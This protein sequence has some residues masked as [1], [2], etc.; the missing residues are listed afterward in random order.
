MAATHKPHGLKENLFVALLLGSLS[1]PALSQVVTDGSVGPAMALTGPDFQIGENLGTR[2]GGN[3]FHS[4]GQFSLSQEQSAT[5]TGSGDIDHVISRVTGGQASSIDGLLKSEV[6]NADFWFINPAGVVFGPNARLEVPAAFHL[7]SADQ[8]QFADGAVFSAVDANGS[9][10]TTAAPEAFGFLAP[11]PE[12]VR[13]EASQLELADGQRMTLSGGSL[14]VENAALSA[15]DGELHLVAVGGAAGGAAEVAIMADGDPSLAGGMASGDLVVENSILSVEGLSGGR[16]SLQGG[17]TRLSMSE[18]AART[19]WLGDGQGLSISANGLLDVEYSRISTSTYDAGKAGNVTIHA[20]S[21]VIDGFGDPEG[22]IGIFSSTPYGSGS[23]GT[24][25]IQVDHEL[26]LFN[27]ALISTDTWSGGEGG[28][29]SIHAGE[30]LL[31]GQGFDSWYTTGIYADTIDGSG[32]GG[33]IDI[34]SDGALTLRDGAVISSDTYGDGDG[35]SVQ[36]TAQSAILDGG[37][38]PLYTYIGTN[39]LS[40]TGNG[41]GVELDIAEGLVLQGGAS[42]FSVTEASGRAGSIRLKAG[43]VRLDGMGAVQDNGIFSTTHGGSG[44]GGSIDLQIGGELAVSGGSLIASSTGGDG[45]AGNLA[46]HAGSAIVDGSGTLQP[47]GIYAGGYYQSTGEGGSLEMVVENDLSILSLGFISSSAAGSGDAGHILVRA[48]SA[49]LD[50]GGIG[51]G[52]GY[53]RTGI[54]ADAEFGSGNAQRVSVLVEDTLMLRDDAEISS[55]TIDGSL[56]NAGKV[57]VEADTLTIDGGG[58][59]ATGIYSNARGDEGYGPAWGDVG[60]VEVHARRIELRD[61]GEIGIQNHGLGGGDSAHQVRVAGDVL[62]L[63]DA[64]IATESSGHAPAGDIELAFSDR[65]SLT[66]SRINTQANNGDGGDIFIDPWLVWLTDSQI[67]TSVAGLAGDGGDITLITDNLVMEGGFIQ[68]NT[69][70]TGA[71]GGLIQIRNDALIPFGGGLEIGD[72]QRLAFEPGRNVIQAAAPDGVSGDIQ[73]AA[74]DVDVVSGL[75]ALDTGFSDATRLYQNPCAG[76]AA[77]SSRLAW[78]GAGGLPWSIGD[79]MLSEL[80]ADT[81]PRNPG[82]WIGPTAGFRVAA[83]CG[84]RSQTDSI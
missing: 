42:L 61:G 29:I 28:S 11:R 79:P 51:E 47:T 54:Y 30:L 57:R 56:G 71:S 17:D 41:G 25:E 48:G 35:G 4:F 55:S 15:A 5:F 20:R 18:I 36:V 81:E 22:E 78:V 66:R 65:V 39:A 83:H 72:Q 7:S 62:I 8:L 50:G 10:L 60:D 14:A 73:I 46:I 77:G 12:A 16:I 1:S 26:A 40:G 27:G 64:E 13:V 70:A 52:L 63:E 19:L 45:D 68:A 6:G 23:A 58:L 53:L 80:S 3:L 84:R 67:T 74:P 82:A 32:D 59:A 33:S 31:D 49:T 75:L 38:L 24:I 37:G 2:A 43:S 76:G 21:M 69:A 9:G 44:A 34:Q